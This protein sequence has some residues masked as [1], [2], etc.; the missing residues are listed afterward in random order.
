ML[1]PLPLYDVFARLLSY[2]DP[3]FNVKLKEAKNILSV[4]SVQVCSSSVAEHFQSFIRRV[5]GNSIEELEE[6][7]TRTFDIN[8][9]VNLE[10][11]WL[12]YGEQYERGA[13]L[14]TMRR[15]L[16]KHAVEESAE[17]PDHLTHVLL[18]M[19]RMEKQEAD[20]FSEKYLLPYFK[21]LLETFEAN[22]NPYHDL[23]LAI[24]DHV[25]RQ[26]AEGVV[27]HE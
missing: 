7:Y 12:L 16:A 24:R 22:D 23:L 14:V 5:E 19:G 1:S 10:I 9:V 17:L 6:L 15:L 26:H 11:G 18:A 4:D 21:K 27:T 13:F 25:Q 3:Q 2:P 20:E 8:P